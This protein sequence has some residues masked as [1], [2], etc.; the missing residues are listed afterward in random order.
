MQMLM[1]RSHVQLLQGMAIY[2]VGATGVQGA[3]ASAA[4]ITSWSPA[5]SL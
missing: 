2:G 1:S 4:L 3:L 5:W